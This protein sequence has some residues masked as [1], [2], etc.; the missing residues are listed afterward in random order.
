[1]KPKTPAPRVAE[2]LRQGPTEGGSIGRFHAMDAGIIDRMHDHAEKA[3]T[4]QRNRRFPA[5][6]RAFDQVMM[7]EAENSVPSTSATSM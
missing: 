5:S 6:N 1:M 3:A 4:A 2:Y 7:A